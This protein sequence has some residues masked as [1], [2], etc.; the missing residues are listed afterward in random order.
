[1]RGRRAG[2]LGHSRRRGYV[3]V[4]ELRAALQAA[5]EGLVGVPGRGRSGVWDGRS[6]EVREESGRSS[7]VGW[8]YSGVERRA[9]QPSSK[10]EAL[11]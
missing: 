4:C 7:Y 11:G 1:M 6:P 8:G 10:V 3:G 5:V 9:L 2:A